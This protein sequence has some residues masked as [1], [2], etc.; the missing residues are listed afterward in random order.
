MTKQGE[1]IPRGVR[2][3]NGVLI[4][5]HLFSLAW[6]LY[7]ILDHKPHLYHKLIPAGAAVCCLVL[8]KLSPA[9]RVRAALALGGLLGGL[10]AA[11]IALGMLD[12]ERARQEAIRKVAR[13]KGVP[14]DART[15]LQVITDLRKRSILAYPAFHPYTL[16][17]SPL[18]VEGVDTIPVSGV[19][20]V[21]TISCN[22]GGQYLTFQ[23]DERG[24][25]NPPGLWSKSRADIAIVGDSI[26]LGECVAPPD[27]I[28][29]QL[30]QRHPGTI[31]LGAGGN[32]PLLELAALKEYLPA[33]KPQRVLWFFY[34]GN[35]MDNLEEEKQSRILIRYLNSRFRQGLPQRQDALNQA[36]AAYLEAAIQ[37]EGVKRGSWHA[38]LAGFLFLKQ[39][40]VLIWKR[41]D[42]AFAL[43][44]PSGDFTTLERILREAHRTV[45][46]W[47]GQLIVVYLPAPFRYPD[48]YQFSKSSR[49]W[50]DHIHAEVLKVT[51]KLGIP[52]IDAI[53]SFPDEPGNTKFFYPY[54]AH[55]TPEG[56]RAVGRTILNGLS[57]VYTFSRPESL[58]ASDN[59][60]QHIR[61]GATTYDPQNSF[62][63]TSDWPRGRTCSLGSPSVGMVDCRTAGA[64]S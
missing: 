41:M 55:Y 57:S 5:G 19:A 21:V 42:V 7:T 58:E 14:F 6:L 26:A 1:L 35:D 23:T 4:L 40:R 29:S 60:S 37:A 31:T 30:R 12:P 49:R 61:R 50:L 59:R 3:A 47:G 17:D 43:D 28:A 53:R 13:D 46:S 24:F 63:P 56:Y 20:R 9:A 34:E 15:R 27:S 38:S 22:E 33:L 8:L 44:R 11:E 62:F 45:E 64:G 10:Y 32:G 18:S 51:R 16:L 2:G 39:L 36:I 48:Q 25:P 52:V 54:L